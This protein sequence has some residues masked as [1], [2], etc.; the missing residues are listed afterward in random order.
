MKALVLLGLLVLAVAGCENVSGLYAES[1]VTNEV[2][3]TGTYLKSDEVDQAP[4]V[5]DQTA[6]VY[7]PRMLKAE[8]N[9]AALVGLIVDEHGN[10]QQVQVQQAT[11]PLFGDAAV[12]AVKRWHFKPG[13]K[14]GQA[15]ATAMTLP[16]QFVHNPVTDRPTGEEK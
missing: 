4:V 10:P 7:P 3:F 5:L 13:Q 6:P 12:E 14:G 1:P 2:H 9:G 11:H 16:I 15:V 8:M